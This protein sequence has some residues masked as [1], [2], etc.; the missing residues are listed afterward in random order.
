VQLF[1][2][3]PVVKF[4]DKGISFAA[5]HARMFS[6]IAKQAPMHLFLADRRID[7]RTF[8]VLFCVPLVV[9]RAVDLVTIFTLRMVQSQCFVLVT[10]AGLRLFLE[11]N[12]ASEQSATSL[13]GGNLNSKKYT[14]S[15]G[16]MQEGQQFSLVPYQ[17]ARDRQF[18]KWKEGV[19]AQ[20][21]PQR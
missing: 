21:V 7:H 11:A 15:C 6:K 20:E 13:F 2:A 14:L 4:Q 12:A 19:K 16:E 18:C 8:F 10:K 1:H 9:F 3:V 17:E 5:I